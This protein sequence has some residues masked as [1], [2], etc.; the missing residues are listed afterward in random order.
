MPSPSTNIVRDPEYSRRR[1]SGGIVPDPSYKYSR[2]QEPEDIPVRMNL[3]TLYGITPRDA[4]KIP[5]EWQAPGFKKHQEPSVR[6][7]GVP[8]GTKLAGQMTTEDKARKVFAYYDRGHFEGDL[9]TKS[10]YLS[11]LEK[12]RME[13]AGTATND[14]RVGAFLGQPA[15]PKEGYE[16][17]QHLAAEIS[18]AVSRKLGYRVTT[19]EVQAIWWLLG[20]SPK[21]AKT[22]EGKTPYKSGSVESA[23][24][25]S[26]DQLALFKKTYGPPTPPVT[27]TEFS[28]RTLRTKESPD[29]PGAWGSQKVTMSRDP[30]DFPMT[31]KMFEFA[32]E[33]QLAQLPSKTKNVV[34][35][36]GDKEAAAARI[37]A[38]AEVME[39]LRR[40][41][42]KRTGLE[43]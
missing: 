23:M 3:T 4:G 13:A 28:P 21:G 8:V 5:K 33:G 38:G 20:E 40:E 34:R 32:T 6:Q 29:D 42:W 14:V 26:K 41:V 10:F 24:A 30:G 22:V 43:K 15:M 11:T 36:L 9:K 1:F 19:D 37:A 16:A 27:G 18:R 25:Y 31:P 12:E 7:F 2:G 35:V 39:E 17:A